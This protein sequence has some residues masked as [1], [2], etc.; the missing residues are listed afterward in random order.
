[1][2]LTVFVPGLV[3]VLT[4]LLM[5]NLPRRR[6]HRLIPLVQGILESH[7]TQHHQQSKGSL[8]SKYL[9]YRATH[10]VFAEI[11]HRSILA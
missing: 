3:S 2:V 6:G 10:L 1:M 11:D 9:L 8:A 4:I 5:K 7:S